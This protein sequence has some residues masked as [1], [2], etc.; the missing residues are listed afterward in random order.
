MSKT[1]MGSR[2]LTAN[3]FAFNEEFEK[4][5][6]RYIAVSEDTVSSSSTP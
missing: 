4:A 1:E 5:T 2:R 6:D 3:R